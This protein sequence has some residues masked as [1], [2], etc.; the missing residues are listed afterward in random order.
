MALA[1]IA[2]ADI[3]HDGLD[4]GHD[5]LQTGPTKWQETNTTLMSTTSQD[6]GVGGVVIINEYMVEQGR[7]S[8]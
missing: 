1:C 2:T 7:L 3:S 4:D 8:G 6:T 5:G